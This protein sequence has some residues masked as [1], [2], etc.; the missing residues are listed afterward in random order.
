MNYETLNQ[1][2]LVSIF[3]MFF[4]VV[5]VIYF[6]I[7]KNKIGFIAS[8]ILVVIF[9]ATAGTF[10]TY[11]D[12][13]KMKED[14]QEQ[15]SIE[16]DQEN[17]SDDDSDS[18]SEESSEETS[19]EESDSSDESSS[20]E[21]DSSGIEA[22]SRGERIDLAVDNMQDKFSKIAHVEYDKKLKAIKVIPK[23]PNSFL[24][25][26]QQAKSSGDTS[27]WDEMT[28]AFDTMSKSL[29]DDFK[30]SS[31]PIAIINPLGGDEKVLYETIDG[32][33]VYNEVKDNN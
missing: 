26:V 4:F 18:E 2:T 5:L 13:A 23:D 33:T 25:E 14:E 3:I 27:S 1:Y 8:M 16:K 19:S 30:L 20:D 28:D 31:L 7:K 17:Y 24:A 32:T 29:H 10:Q 22:Y 15:A 21:S 9:F 11:A 12:K 6:G